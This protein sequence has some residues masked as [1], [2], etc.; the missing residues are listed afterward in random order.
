MALQEEAQRLEQR[1]IAFI[2]KGA[3]EWELWGICKRD[4]LIA[5]CRGLCKRMEVLHN[6]L[7]RLV[8]VGSLY[9]MFRTR[10]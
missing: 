5:V 3:L 6:I 1:A 9:I 10:L 8:I 7:Y 4:Y 2:A